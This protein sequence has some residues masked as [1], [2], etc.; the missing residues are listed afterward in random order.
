MMSYPHH[1]PHT[2]L[3]WPW[4]LTRGHILL[5]AETEQKRGVFQTEE[6]KIHIALK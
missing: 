1:T 4:S 6:D 3:S 2:Y 5:A